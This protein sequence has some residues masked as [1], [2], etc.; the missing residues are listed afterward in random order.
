[1][2]LKKLSQLKVDFN[3]PDSQG[4]RPLDYAQEEEIIEL[5]IQLGAD[6]KKITDATR[7]RFK[8]MDYDF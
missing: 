2:M 1:M 7:Q 4:L 6:A 3:L 8:K 5:L